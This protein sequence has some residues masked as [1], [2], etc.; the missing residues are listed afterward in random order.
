MFKCI[1]SKS[2]LSLR[3]SAE[4]VEYREIYYDNK[5]IYYFYLYSGVLHYKKSINEYMSTTLTKIILHT[6]LFC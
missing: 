1:L 4:A 5:Y 2:F 6:Y 3:Y